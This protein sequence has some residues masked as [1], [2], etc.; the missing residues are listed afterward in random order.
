MSRFSYLVGRFSGVH[1]WPVLSVPRGLTTEAQ[2]QLAFALMA[3]S[4][5]SRVCFVVVVWLEEHRL[6]IFDEDLAA[7][8]IAIN[9]DCWTENDLRRLI[10]KGAALLNIDFDPIFKDTLIQESSSSVHVVQEACRQ[11]CMISQV[12]GKEATTTMVGND[13]N[14]QH[15]IRSILDQKAS[16]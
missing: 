6:T 13:L 15:I 12:K 10:E 4:E 8:L 5:W 2:R 16:H 14:V 11:A 7:R 1:V 9:A 3:F